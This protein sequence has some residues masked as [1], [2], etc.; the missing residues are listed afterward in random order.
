M[1]VTGRATLDHA[2]PTHRVEPPV[3]SRTETN[4][5]TTR[6]PH[7]PWRFKQRNISFFNS[8]TIESFISEIFRKIFFIVFH[9]FYSFEKGALTFQSNVN[10]RM[11]TVFENLSKLKNKQSFF[12]SRSGGFWNKRFNFLYVN[13][14]F[15]KI[16]NLP[17]TRFISATRQT[18]SSL[19]S[20]QRNTPCARSI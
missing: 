18:S 15:T 16:H 10:K 9:L 12:S 13:V 4:V 1:P 20:V 7:S 3:T 17:K 5:P 6:A 8:S 2:D 11:K 19:Y 14:K